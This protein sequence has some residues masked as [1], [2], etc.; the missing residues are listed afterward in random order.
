MP[1]HAG[2]PDGT[3]RITN[4]S[5]GKNGEGRTYVIRIP[6]EIGQAVPDGTLFK[7]VMTEDG[8]MFKIF[9]PE[10]EKVEVPSWAKR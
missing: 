7:P 4:H 3:Y 1:R 10:D 2:Q 8:I 9:D 5:S 6:P